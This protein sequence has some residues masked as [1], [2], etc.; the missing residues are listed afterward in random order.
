MDWET[1]WEASL[2]LI[3]EDG[4]IAVGAVGAILATWLFTRMADAQH[5]E[6]MLNLAGPLLLAMIAMLVL[7]NL[8]AAGR[9]AA[10]KRVQ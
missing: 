4:W 9:S 3:I 2:G 6:E 1:L 10:R 7:A 8:Y 5:N